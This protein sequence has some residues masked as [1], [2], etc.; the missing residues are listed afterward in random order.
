[1][2]E[3]ASKAEMKNDF[4]YI[5]V[6]GGFDLLFGLVRVRMGAGLMSDRRTVVRSEGF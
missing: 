3:A 1:M 2:A 4:A 5:V 6:D